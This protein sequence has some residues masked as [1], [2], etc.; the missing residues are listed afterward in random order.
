MRLRKSEGEVLLMHCVEVMASN[1][2]HATWHV[3]W[4][5]LVC[6]MQTCTGCA[7]TSRMLSL[8]MFAAELLILLLC[9][10]VG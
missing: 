4:M 8:R 2:S 3:D 1:H 9:S 5:Q 10:Q 7:S 6:L